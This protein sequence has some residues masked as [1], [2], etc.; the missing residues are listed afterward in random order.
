MGGRAGGGGGVVGFGPG[1]GEALYASPGAFL[2]GFT[3]AWLDFAILTS[4]AL[5]RNHDSFTR[6]GTN[7]SLCFNYTVGFP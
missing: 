3:R 4:R 5:G 7:K 2:L 1:L 6:F